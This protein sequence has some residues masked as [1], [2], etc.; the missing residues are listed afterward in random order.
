MGKARSPPTRQLA[1]AGRATYQTYCSVITGDS[2][3]APGRHAWIQVAREEVRVNGEHLASGDGAALSD[4]SQL[5]L[6]GIDN[7]EVLVFD[8]A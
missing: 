4:I 5:H 8:L 6:D 7:A 2:P 3:L 1:L